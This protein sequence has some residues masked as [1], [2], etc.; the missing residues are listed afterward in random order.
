[1]FQD[2]GVEDPIGLG[3]PLPRE[4][5]RWASSGIHPELLCSEICDPRGAGGAGLDGVSAE[6]AADKRRFPRTL[7]HRS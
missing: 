6:R 1:M 4:L 5:S 3:S 2:R 7:H